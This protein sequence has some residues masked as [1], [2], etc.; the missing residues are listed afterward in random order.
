MATWAKVGDGSVVLSGE[1]VYPVLIA[2]TFHSENS[3]FPRTRWWK[4]PV[5]ADVVNH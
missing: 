3:G 5:G 1:A 4:T 2:E